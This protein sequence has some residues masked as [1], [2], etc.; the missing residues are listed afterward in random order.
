MARAMAEWLESP[1][2]WIGGVLIALVAHYVF[3]V[4]RLRRPLDYAEELRLPTA[5][6]S[7]IVLRRILPEGHGEGPPVL[8]VHGIAAN[9]RN[10]D[11]EEHLSLARVIAASG[12][13]TWLVT[14][15]AG[16]GDR[17]F[18][19]PVSTLAMARQDLPLAVEYVCDRTESEVI[20]FVGFSMGGMLMLGALPEALPVRRL[21][22]A[23][24]LAAPSRVI[25]PLPA[26]QRLPIPLALLPPLPL[27]FV[28]RM[29]AFASEWFGTPLHGWV[30]NRKNTDRGSTARAL[31]NLIEDVPL[32][33]GRDFARWAQGDGTIDLEG[34]PLLTG[35]DEV[36]PID[37]LFIAG[38]ADR[39]AP[40]AAVRAGYDAWAG[41]KEYRELG[42][43]GG[44]GEDYGHG[45]LVIGKR[46]VQEVF[47][48]IRDFL[49]RD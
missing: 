22:R 21:R 29:A 18:W 16:R 33:V 26:L 6:G 7:A 39:V 10:I 13:D 1:L 37:A 36:R 47:E 48:P 23:V 11:A 4:W 30:Y 32:A 20:D 49:N 12:R 3:W 38:S 5:D 44:A 28:A 24:F 8:L 35:L 2:F 27:R 34:T 25:T 15:R 40:P 45:D 43:A 19:E 46:A 41:A 9:H 14:L 31:V 42:R 17:R